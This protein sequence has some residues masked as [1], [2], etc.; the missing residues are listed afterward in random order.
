MG[1]GPLRSKRLEERAFYIFEPFP[2][3]SNFGNIMDFER[4]FL[5][6]NWDFQTFFWEVVITSARLGLG[7]DI[8]ELMLMLISNSDR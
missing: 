2:S 8:S 1:S 6:K 7:M 4:I 5:W 3:N